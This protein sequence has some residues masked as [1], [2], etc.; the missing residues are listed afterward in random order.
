MRHSRLNT[1]VE[2]KRIN[3]RLPFLLNVKILLKVTAGQRIF[4]VLL[5]ERE[6]GDEKGD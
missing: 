3:L 4:A 5:G 1:K 2:Q 6:K